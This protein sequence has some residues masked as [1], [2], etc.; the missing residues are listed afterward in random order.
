M[1][2][3]K[4]L[5]MD[6]TYGYQHEQESTDGLKLPSLVIGAGSESSGNIQ[7]S[8]TAKIVGLANGTDSGDAVNKG[9]L[10]AA[11]AGYDWQAPVSVLKIKSDAAQ[12]GSPPTAGAAGEAW[13]VNTWG[14]GYTNGDIVEWDGTQW[15]VVVTNSG[16]EPPDG[17]RVA[18]I[19]VSAAGSFSSHENA[20]GTYNASANTWSFVAASDGDA[21]LVA[22]EGSIYENYGFV[23]DTSA[24][25]AFTGPN[26][27]PDATSGSGG[28]V[29]G[30]VTF[31]S[32][33]G[34]AVTAGVAE[35]KL[36]TAGT[37]TGGL[38]FDGSGD[39]QI[40]VNASGGLEL[41]AS[42]IGVNVDGSTIAI[43][44]SN[45]LYVASIA[46][47]ARTGKTY[48]A[49]EALT[50]ADPVYFS[51]ADTPSKAD[52]ATEAKGRV[53][54]VAMATVVSGTVD[55]CFSGLAA[56]VLTG[57]T[58]N[59]PYYLASGGGLTT[60]RPTG[61]VRI[62]RIGYAASATDLLVQVMDFGRSVS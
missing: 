39:I 33:K 57:A 40:D 6:G 21:V 55:I 26:S 2:I 61:N 20:I 22:G 12:G 16:S 41:T 5:F 36:A 51:A 23:F 8:T 38:E 3:K 53:V 58:Y 19:G 27:I 15:N 59:T 44:G 34:L 28:D 10:D 32:D 9:Q 37:G 11:V 29:K 4:F 54:G 52:A 47:A 46:E 50:K 14:G 25:I 56:G 30:K 62:V 49:G 45:E 18:V 13:V 7:M 31:D 42:G 35:V 60:T 48:T 24:W 17:T 43:N 1:A